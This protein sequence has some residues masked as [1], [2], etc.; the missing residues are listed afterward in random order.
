MSQEQALQKKE[1]Q[2][3]QAVQET[4]EQEVVMQPAV[5]VSEHANGIVLRADL[6]GVHKDDLNIELEGDQLVI[7]GKVRLDLPEELDARYAEIQT[8]R[9]RRSFTLGKDLDGENIEAD[10]KNG[11]LTLRIPKR[12]EVLPRKISI[13]SGE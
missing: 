13:K 11:V 12:A 4:A 1:Q 3:V 8:S 9:Y 6:P 2:A 7:D 10:L 5:D